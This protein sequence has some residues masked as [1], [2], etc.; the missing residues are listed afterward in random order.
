MAYNRNRVPTP[1]NKSLFSY[2]LPF[3]IIIGLGVL[4]TLAYNMMNN[5][6]TLPEIMKDAKVYVSVEEGNAQAN[7]WG[8]TSLSEVRDGD[9]LFQGDTITTDDEARVIL[10]FFDKS[11][12]RL[13]ADTRLTLNTLRADEN[14]TQVTITLEKGSAWVVKNNSGTDFVLVTENT[15]SSLDKAVVAIDSHGG[16]ENIYVINGQ[17]N[18]NVVQEDK[19]TNKN[20]SLQRFVLETGEQILL[21]AQKIEALASGGY[22]PPTEADE[23]G[24]LISGEGEDIVELSFREPIGENFRTNGW[25]TYNASLD[26]DLFVFEEEVVASTDENEDD[27][28]EAEDSE[29]NEGPIETEINKEIITLV[30]PKNG[31]EYNTNK[32]TFKGDLWGAKVEKVMVNDKVA[33]LSDETWNC[34]VNLEKEGPNEFKIAGYDAEDGLLK[35]ISVSVN[36]DTT[37]PAKPIIATPENNSTQENAEGFAISGTASKDTQKI[38]VTDSAQKFAYALSAYLPGESEWKY[39]ARPSFGNLAEGENTYAVVAVDKAGNKS[40]EAILVVNYIKPEEETAEKPEENVAEEN[41][42]EEEEEEEAAEEKTTVVD[43]NL[44]A[45]II[46]IPTAEST[47][48][49]TLDA[50]SIGGTTNQNTAKIYV[51]GVAIGNYVEGNTRWNTSVNLVEGENKFTVMAENAS[52]NKSES[53]TIN[54]LY[55]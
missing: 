52:G 47:Y 51:N 31:D 12:V 22:I 10:S 15:I 30:S 16:Y 5:A 40:E 21:N 9:T 54:I 18:M 1:P 34:V 36:Y 2:L 29:S 3:L 46:T 38:I 7:E 4:A 42:E 20:K 24:T 45:P 32:I 13:G 8:K 23:S 53:V 43:E 19:I 6:P 25:F 55:K 50:V 49:T 27:A 26:G 11:I 44:P 28:S 17:V 35:Q 37:A 48:E 41:A 39:N 14:N 33:N